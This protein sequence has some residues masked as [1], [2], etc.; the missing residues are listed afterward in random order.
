MIRLFECNL[1]DTVLVKLTPVGEL[2]YTK[3]SNIRHPENEDHIYD[4]QIWEFMNIFGKEMFL[5]NPNQY[6]ENN[7]LVFRRYNEE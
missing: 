1:N 4:F 6:F 2:L 5:G 7:K 3:H